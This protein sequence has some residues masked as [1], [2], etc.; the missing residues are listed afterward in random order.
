MR[1]R[2]LV[3]YS[4]VDAIKKMNLGTIPDN[5]YLIKSIYSTILKYNSMFIDRNF[6]KLL[7]SINIPA[8]LSMDEQREIVNT[9][10]GI[11]EN[12][13]IPGCK[14]YRLTGSTAITVA[15][16]DMLFDQQMR[17]LFVSLLFVFATLIIVFGSSL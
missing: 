6:S 10:N 15:I 8:G 17:S 4:I 1:E 7:I 12:S 14:I 13:H 3:A 9:I 11:V 16:N 5:R 2:G